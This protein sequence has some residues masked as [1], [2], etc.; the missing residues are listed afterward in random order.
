[1]AGQH[2]DPGGEAVALTNIIVYTVFKEH[3]F[4]LDSGHIMISL[5]MP[6]RGLALT[7]AF[8][9]FANPAYAD[10]AADKP[11]S[12][13]S[14]H[15]GPT[16]RLPE[17]MGSQPRPSPPSDVEEETLLE[18]PTPTE[19]P[20][21]PET[22]Q[23]PPNEPETIQEPPNEPETIQEPPNEPETIQEPPT[24][25]E[26]QPETMPR[27]EPTAA[28]PVNGDTDL[29]EEESEVADQNEDAQQSPNDDGEEDIHEDKDEKENKETS[30]DEANH[31]S[32]K[33][34]VSFI[35][36]PTLGGN[37]VLYNDLKLFQMNAGAIGSLRY[38]A[39]EKPWFGWTRVQAEIL[40]GVPSVSFG[41]DVRAGSFFG[42]QWHGLSFASGPDVSHNGYGEAG[43]EDYYLPYAWGLA[44]VNIVELNILKVLRLS[45]EVH[46]GWVFE[47]TRHREEIGL[48]DELTLV[49]G[50]ELNLK[51]IGIAV[52]Y[53]RW[54]NSA[55]TLDTIGLSFRLHI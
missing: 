18:P 8:I 48:L 21:E 35:G 4:S 16:H 30:K 33:W 43:V 45:F 31:S 37:L 55:G 25:P 51:V 15:T 38:Q 10:E 36:Q 44:W 29:N 40:L 24:E 54:L 53:T 28:P 32:K 39:E 5:R 2:T 42:V 1:M 46:P 49:G 9:L 7:A 17:S 12:G 22:I 27:P 50:A 20:T 23:E 34:T 19:P 14:T 3:L 41:F 47:P 6:L 13:E 11:P 26:V 52:T